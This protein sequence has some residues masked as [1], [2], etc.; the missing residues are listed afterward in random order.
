[1]ALCC[2]VATQ[3]AKRHQISQIVV[4]N[5]QE[6]NEE[7]K[8][9]VE[10]TNRRTFIFP[11]E[12]Q[13]AF[14]ILSYHYFYETKR[15]EAVGVAAAFLFPFKI[16]LRAKERKPF[17]FFRWLTIMMLLMV[18]GSGLLFSSEIIIYYSL[19]LWSNLL[20]LMSIRYGIVCNGIE[21]KR[22]CDPI[23]ENN[24]VCDFH[25]YFDTE[26]DDQNRRRLLYVVFNLRIDRRRWR[27]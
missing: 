5:V 11:I 18:A 23:W 10:S 22:I 9:K 13:N 3:M 7:Y 19:A 27:R 1:M 14:H 12:I 4:E 21:K 26:S 17:S 8:K 6:L 25:F 2:F 20:L 15:A 16:L 24:F